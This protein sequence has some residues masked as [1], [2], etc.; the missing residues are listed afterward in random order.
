MFRSFADELDAFRVI[1]YEAP[2]LVPDVPA[3]DPVT[4]DGDGVGQC[5]AVVTGSAASAEA[6]QAAPTV[7]S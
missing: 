4:N 1:P 3:L 6:V 2:A 5:G 7:C